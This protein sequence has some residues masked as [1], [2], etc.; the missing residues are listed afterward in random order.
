M[1]MD[2]AQI[3]TSTYV[4]VFGLVSGF[5][6]MITGTDEAGA[7][8]MWN[9]PSSGVHFLPIIRARGSGPSLG[10]GCVVHSARWCPHAG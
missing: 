10:R 7:Q 1:F 3:E 6:S 5:A 4:V 9:L 2:S 8:T